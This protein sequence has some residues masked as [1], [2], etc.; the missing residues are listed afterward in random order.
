MAIKYCMDFGR[1]GVYLNGAHCVEP[2]KKFDDNVRRD[3][4]VQEELQAKNIKCLVVWECTIKKMERDPA[5]EETVMEQCEH[6]LVDDKIS[7]RLQNLESF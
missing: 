3:K 1:G 7:D 5:I 4:I 2:Q 6:F